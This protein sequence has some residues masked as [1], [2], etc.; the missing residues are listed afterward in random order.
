MAGS[1]T[2]PYLDLGPPPSRCE[3]T[4]KLKTV[5]SH[6][7]RMRAVTSYDNF[8]RTGIE[9]TFPL[10]TSHWAAAHAMPF[11]SKHVSQELKYNWNEV[12]FVAAPV[13]T[14]WP[15][16]LTLT[17]AV[18]KYKNH[19]QNIFLIFLLHNVQGN[20]SSVI[21]LSISKMYKLF[22]CFKDVLCVNLHFS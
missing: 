18:G 15:H 10:E 1:G 14:H 22:I 7:L 6:I 9:I 20:S 16:F 4:N 12:C 8:K 11:S 17:F 13:A 3:L 2:P 19:K 5:P 21:I